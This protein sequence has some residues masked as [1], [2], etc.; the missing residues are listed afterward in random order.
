[1]RRQG[2]SCHIPNIL[3]ESVFQELEKGSSKGSGVGDGGI[4]FYIF[5]YSPQISIITFV[6]F[7]N[8]WI[9][10]MQFLSQGRRYDSTQ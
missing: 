9:D 5:K 10:D 4:P 7:P 6:F 3:I 8:I 1:M 2:V